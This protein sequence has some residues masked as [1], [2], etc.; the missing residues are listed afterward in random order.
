MYIPIPDYTKEYMVG[1][2]KTPDLTKE[3][4]ELTDYFINKPIYKEIPAQLFTKISTHK[5]LADFL[6]EKNWSG[7][8]DGIT[9]SAKLPDWMPHCDPEFETF[10][11]GEESHNKAKTLSTLRKGDLLIFYATLCPK[12]RSETPKKYIIGFFIID[13]VFNYRK[14]LGKRPIN[15]NID[16]IP[17]DIQKNA[18]R[19]D[20]EPE[21]VIAKG[22]SQESQ[23]LE[24]AIPLSDENYLV[25]SELAD[26]IP[27]HH[28]TRDITRHIRKFENNSQF[29]KWMEV[30][31]YNGP[32]GLFD[33]DLF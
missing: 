10:T 3:D 15:Y 32:P 5:K 33:P 11:Y 29:E 27:W 13:T 17:Q 12:I 18:H 28:A 31:S 4:L 23:L 16:T 25:Y 1:W 22:N 14:S 20:Y 26:F 9:Y 7:K 2:S 8:I 6:E 24:K 21:P 30:L 19:K